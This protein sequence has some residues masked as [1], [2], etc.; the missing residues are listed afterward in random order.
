MSTYKRPAPEDDAVNSSRK[1][2]KS[3]QNDEA[4]IQINE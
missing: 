1:S 2:P 4:E 3:A